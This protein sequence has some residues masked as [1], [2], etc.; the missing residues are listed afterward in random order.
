MILFDFIHLSIPCTVWY[1]VNIA[2][3]KFGKIVPRG[4]EPLR[5]KVDTRA[6]LS[7]CKIGKLYTRTKVNTRA[8]LGWMHKS[9]IDV[10]KCV[11]YF[12]MFILLLL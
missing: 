11:S 8:K 2:D 10:V 9:Q 7:S 12:N 1:A 6:K 5:D 4:R 3:R